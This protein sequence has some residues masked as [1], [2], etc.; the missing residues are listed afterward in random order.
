MV[1]Y[2]AKGGAA[3]KNSAPIL[4]LQNVLAHCIL[5]SWPTFHREIDLAPDHCHGADNLIRLFPVGR[6]GHVVSQLGYTLLG[7]KPREQNIRVWQIE[8]PDTSFLE[9]WLNLKTATSLIVE[10]GR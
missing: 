9:L 7:K 4:D 5:K 8:L 2:R 3:R 1:E 10:Q 6:N